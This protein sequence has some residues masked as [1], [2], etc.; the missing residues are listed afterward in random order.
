MSWS[1]S[2]G[3]V[4]VVLASCR[5]SPTVSRS[6]LVMVSIGAGSSVADDRV[7]LVVCRPQRGGVRA[8]FVVHDVELACEQGQRPL[9]G[10]PR[11][12]HGP[13]FCVRR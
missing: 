3:D 2:C 9:R 6:T 7:E 10:A 11:V 12:G 4:W 1:I 5:R 8:T 13:L